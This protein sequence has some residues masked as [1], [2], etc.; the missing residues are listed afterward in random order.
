MKFNLQA[1]E[2]H[3]LIISFSLLHY[4][5]VLFLFSICRH[6]VFIK[7]SL[8]Q[9]KEVKTCFLNP[10][11]PQLRIK[12]HRLRGCHMKFWTILFTLYAVII[13]KVM[14]LYSM[15]GFLALTVNDLY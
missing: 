11:L 3:I 7:Y 8:A 10:N 1:L 15:N 14:T 5:P 9:N 6:C 4:V 13:S 12:Y 2:L